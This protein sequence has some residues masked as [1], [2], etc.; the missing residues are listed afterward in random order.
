MIGAGAGASNPM[1]DLPPGGASTLLLFLSPIPEKSSVVVDMMIMLKQELSGGLPVTFTRSSQEGG[2]PV[3]ALSWTRGR[4]AASDLPPGGPADSLASTVN[5]RHGKITFSLPF[6]FLHMCVSN[7]NCFRYLKDLSSKSIKVCRERQRCLGWLTRSW[8]GA[9]HS[10]ACAQPQPC[11]MSGRDIRALTI[12]L[13]PTNI[14]QPQP[15]PKVQPQPQPCVQSSQDIKIFRSQPKPYVRPSYQT[16]INGC[17]LQ[18]GPQH[19]E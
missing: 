13:C 19:L 4:C 16:R 17:K 7:L 2:L 8:A 6:E 10:G 9:E 18:M 15:P 3:T 11:V 1:L 14:P 5:G 12:I